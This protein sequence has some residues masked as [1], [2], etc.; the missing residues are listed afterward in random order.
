MPGRVKTCGACGSEN[1]FRRNQCIN[2]GLSLK[3]GRPHDT[4]QYAG[5]KVSGGRPLGTAQQAGYRE[6]GGR[7]V[8]TTQ[9]AG[10]S[11]SGGRPAGKKP[12][13]DSSIHLPTE[14]DHSPQFINVDGD[15]LSVCRRR[16]AQQRTYDKKPLGIAVCYKC[17]HM[18]WSCVDGAHT[19][20]VNKPSGIS[21]GEAPASAYLRAVPNC[22]TG[23]VYTERG[24]STKER[25]YCCAYCKSNEIPSEQHVG[26]VFDASLN[27]KPVN[28]WEM[29]F[30]TEI[31][32]LANQYER[33]QTSLCGLFSSTVKEASMCQYRH[34]QG[35]VNAI[36][37][38]D[39]H[40]HGLFGFLAVKDSD[41]WQR[42]PSPVSSLRI[43]KAIRWLH[44]NNHL[45][46][47]FF[48][49]YE[50]L[51]R[52]C[53]PSFINP[54]LLEDQSISLEKLLEDEAA[55]MAFPLDAKYFDDFP[56]IH[57]DLHADVAGRQYPRPELNK[58]I[59]DLCQAKYG[60]MYLDCKTFPHLHPWGYGGWYHKC[61][62]PFN[63]HVKMRIFDIRG[64]Y[65][66]DRC[67]PF[68][69]YDYM[70]KVRLR[71]HEARKVVKVRSLSEPL[72]AGRVTQR[73][74]PYSV[75]GTEIP[76]II[77]GSKE[78]WRSFGLDLVAFVEQRGL[79]DFF[80]TLTAYDGWPQVQAT[81]RN[82]W[83]AT[84]S[85]IDAQDLSKD[86]SDRQPVGPKPQISVLAAE[87]RYDWFMSIL[88]SP[89]GGP[90][91]VVK[92]SVVK[93]EYQR[94]GA[95]HW[96][97]L[98]WVEPG[99]APK[100]AVMAEMP[101]SA[102][103]SDVVAAYLRKLVDNMLKHKVCYPSRCF[104]GSHGKVLSKCKYG[105]PFDVP[106]D[107]VCLDE[108][109]VRYLYV[110]R[111][112]EDKCV[113]PYNPEIA[114]LWGAA[115]NVQVV[116]KHGFE[117]YL[118]KYISKPEPSFKIELPENCSAPQRFLRSRVVGSVEVLDVL[119]GFHQNQMSRKVIFL[120]TELSP[121][122]RMLKP[123]M[124]LD[125]M[126][127][128]GEDIYLQTKLE[129]Y[130]KRPPQLDSITY[131]E[132]Y[133]WWRSSTSQEQKKAFQ[134]AL[135]RKPLMIKC[136][137][138]D[139][140]QGYQLARSELA[141]AEE[142]L[143][144]I[145]SECD[146]DINSTYD[147]I[148]LKMCL[149]SHDISPEVIAAVV[150]HYVS[151]GIDLLDSV[152]D[153]IP[154]ESLLLAQNIVGAIDLHDTDIIEGLNAYHWLM[155]STP[156]DELVSVLTSYPPGTVLADRVGHYWIRRAR[157]V[158][159]R[160]RFINSVGDDTEKFYQQK[161]L[162]T[163]PLTEDDDVVLNPPDSWVELCAQ[164]GMCDAHLD[165][166]SCLQSAISRGFHTD[167]L[168]S[169]AQLYVE[170][171]FL[172]DDE[173]GTFLSDIPVLGEHDETE[174]TVTDRMLGDP[175]SDVGDL[176]PSTSE[177]TVDL[178][179]F[180]QTFTESQLRVYR[181]VEG[182]FD[183]NKQIRAAIVGPAGTGKSYLLKG[184]IELAKSKGLVVSKLAPSGVAAH[185]IGG[186]TVH[187]FFVLDVDCNS[188]L[189]NGTV[190]VAKLRKTDVLVI[191]EF[192]MLD[193]YLFRTA[194]CLC[195][196]FA[197]HRVSKFPWGGR[198]VIMLGDPAQLPA[199]S[200]RDIFGTKLWRTF[201]IL[202]LREIKRCQDPVLSSVLSKVRMGVCDQ[203]VTQVLRDR[204]KPRDID[205]LE[206]DRT[207]VIC[208]TR[209]EC[210][211]INDLCIKRMDGNETVYEA[212]D[213]DHHGHP[214]REGDK[215]TVLKYRERL[216]DQLV[217][218]VGAR[219]VLR[220]NMNIEGG[221]VNGTL[222]VIT[223]LHPS[224]IVVVKLANPTHKYPVP[225]FRQRI[226]IRGA[227]YSILRQ[228]FPL[229]L[230][231][232]V[233]V[234]RVQ[235]CTVQK[236]VVC[237]GESFFAS[238]QA[239]VALSRV[240]TLQDLVLWQF[241]PSAIFLHP[242]YLQLLKWC[243][244]VDVVRPTPP[245][246]VVEHPERNEDIFSNDPIPEPNVIDDPKSGSIKFSFDPSVDPKSS[247][248]PTKRGRGRPRKNKAQ[249]PSDTMVSKDKPKPGRKRQR[250]NESAR[251]SALKHPCEVPQRGRKG[252]KRGNSKVGN[253]Q[254][255]TKIPKVDTNIDPHV[256]G[257][258]SLASTSLSV[259]QFL[260]SVQSLLGFT[261]PEA[262]LFS[263]GLLNSV[264]GIIDT[265][266]SMS[267][268]LESVAQ[269][270]NA[271]PTPFASMLPDL[272]VARSVADLCHP[273]MLE[274]F[275]PVAT[276]A[277]GNCMYH[278]LSRVVCGTEQL[279]ILFR[280]L[281]AY[282]A[283]KYTGVMMGALRDAFPWQTHDE[284]VHKCNTL[285]VSALQIGSWGSD[286]QLFLLSFL[287]D[288]PVFVY[289]TF[290]VSDSGVRSLT[291]PDCR[292]VSEFARRF[293]DYDA[294]TRRHIL[295]A[296]SVNA[297][298]LLSGDV[299]TLPHLPLAI[300]FCH[301]HWTALLPVS[302]PVLQHVPIPLTRVLTD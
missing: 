112:E 126:S 276:T 169:L 118:A 222:A 28:E 121:Q 98:L 242:F 189:E 48:S 176:V 277:D 148:A 301:D 236:A 53:K 68:F 221:W 181:W 237:L 228:Q 23:F 208:S 151:A 74:D 49:Q 274:T 96:H 21:E 77:P 251:A 155:E 94:R 102:D 67:Y 85:D 253:E 146:Y 182:Q 219:V 82:G 199:V 184:L 227:S 180:V 223:S 111:H 172:S 282:A 206:L 108:E 104:K 262:I 293:L 140:F 283:V 207:V 218:K 233:T 123:K 5:Y 136:K 216:P 163:V 161:F 209:S 38:L 152:Q 248:A 205:S 254:P 268:A 109:G 278:A 78:Y 105:F 168:R 120:Q 285:I 230:A 131:P 198:H 299:T 211:E 167:Q 179:D 250:N 259:S 177:S 134:S 37:K 107:S 166:F 56:I 160:H 292:D 235:G 127:G 150:R 156:S 50:T 11:V 12:H 269:A 52:Y 202:L 41:I 241:H 76:R 81:L 188:T 32:A 204:V 290:Y 115:H 95:V 133:R 45:Y 258:P 27:V 125:S 43:K 31:Q 256:C 17:G 65:A 84:A 33:G 139:D 141:A 39:R 272:R 252:I 263:L 138:P 22:T 117:M 79:P 298:L 46:S 183:Q 220:R 165:A 158:I 143:A 13:F 270:V 19:F 195:R 261:S 159:T 89:D 124:Q 130:L 294:S 55:G 69:K 162:L 284:N 137:G 239:Y 88:R 244:A 64:F 70:L 80:L 246:D 35:E 8:G 192:S 145:L 97:M 213:T 83:G 30:P 20:L 101:R 280:L 245:T 10:Y 291:L 25:W 178:N 114:I 238:G 75:Y 193:Y 173:A 267:T 265:L 129:T 61:P 26:N 92:D 240:R 194:E 295:N 18:L 234:H 90:L 275:T 122:Q 57:R 135:K 224:C 281:T 29:S 232:G 73:H 59:I 175:Q 225:R 119:M 190:Q 7:P 273:L 4:T 149:E 203:E 231:Y 266:N 6:S 264:Q 296:S 113:V 197:K 226:E 200:R 72:T 217:L 187:N 99:T 247:D 128:D 257:N 287:L 132:F 47:K 106:Q 60:E 185:L 302:A 300:F 86:I 71:M 42:S 40:Y 147:L 255:P 116:S 210:E 66:E 62:I 103:T 144:S 214:L 196:K 186:T 14:W 87:K 164:R 44:V 286:F 260:V 24:D 36:T 170:H 63:A 157:M 249:P 91:G 201:T 191:D 154:V 297:S 2:C 212:I 289:F 153:D 1:H 34:V 288:R 9:I 171:G 229:Q 142:Q 54:S 271:L 110:R 100:H 279:S 16:I 58:S 3:Q 243:D 174:A 215:Q 15:L 51:F 93:K